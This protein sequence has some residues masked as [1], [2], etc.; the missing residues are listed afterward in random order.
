MHEVTSAHLAQCGPYLEVLPMQ[1][2]AV[3]E[4]EVLL[5]LLRASQLSMPA[6]KNVGNLSQFRISIWILMTRRWYVGKGV[7]LAPAVP[8]V[9]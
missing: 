8:A 2:R 1:D 7:V 9:T 4:P 6:L 3:Q 5:Y